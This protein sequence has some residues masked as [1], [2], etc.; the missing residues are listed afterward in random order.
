MFMTPPL[1]VSYPQK[2]KYAM[3][4][5]EEQQEDTDLNGMEIKKEA[6]GDDYDYELDDGMN[7][8]QLSGNKSLKAFLFTVWNR[9]KWATLYNSDYQP[10]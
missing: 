1:H 2:R 3:G 10:M 7:E 9:N 6:I 5:S 4:D 8:N